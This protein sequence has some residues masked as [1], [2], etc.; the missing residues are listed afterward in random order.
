M[1]GHAGQQELQQQQEKQSLGGVRAGCG[2]ATA[3]TIFRD[4]FSDSICT[5]KMLPGCRAPEPGKSTGKYGAVD[6]LPLA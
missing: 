3:P 4:P 5:P 6:N 1:L 2:A